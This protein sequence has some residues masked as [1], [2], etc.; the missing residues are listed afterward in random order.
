MQ[1]ILFQRGDQSSYVQIW[2]L[3]AEKSLIG[4]VVL[5]C[6]KV[7]F[8]RFLSSGFTTMAV[9]NPPERKLVKRTSVHWWAICY[10][11]PG[12]VVF[13]SKQGRC[14]DWKYCWNQTSFSLFFHFWKG[15]VLQKS[16]ILLIWTMHKSKNYHTLQVGAL[17][18][19][20]TPRFSSL[21]FTQSFV[22]Q[23]EVQDLF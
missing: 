23:V 19:G 17:L 2:M 4:R 22:H 12:T 8:A 18:P 20:R 5:H 1:K 11:V 13:W 9:I 21:V 16:K 3:Q 15:K 6:T 14:L 10:Q 7:G